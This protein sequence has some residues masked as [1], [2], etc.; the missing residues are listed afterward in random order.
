MFTSKRW[1]GADLNGYFVEI[2]LNILSKLFYLFQLFKRRVENQ[3]SKLIRKNPKENS[4][5]ALSVKLN[6]LGVSKVEMLQWVMKMLHYITHAALAINPPAD[7]LFRYLPLI[8]IYYIVLR[9]R[10]CV[11]C[12]CMSFVND[13]RTGVCR[14]RWI[15]TDLR[16]NIKVQV[17]NKYY[18]IYFLITLCVGRSI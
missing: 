7:F 16:T 12:W 5:K 10:M 18:I 1:T 17:D 11:L 8:F 15:F 14:K 6:A 4:F 2:F 13:D 9:I 3:A